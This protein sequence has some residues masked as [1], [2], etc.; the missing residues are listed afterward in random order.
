MKAVVLTITLNFLFLFVV[1]SQVVN[2]PDKTKTHFAEK[3]P[4]AKQVDWRNK[5]VNYVATFVLN[6]SKYS[7]WYHM[8]GVWDYTEETLEQ[9]ALP[10]NV[11]TA[12]KNSR[13]SDW[14]VSSTA[15]IEN[16]KGEK[17]Y[18]VEVKKGIEKKYV[19]YDSAGKEI[20]TTGLI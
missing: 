15:Y 2:I 1:Q 5:A 3:Y 13:F 12:L 6:N 11:K 16:N 10:D 19:F 20:R 18:R 9:S 8:D 4:E 14:K 17:L 7:A